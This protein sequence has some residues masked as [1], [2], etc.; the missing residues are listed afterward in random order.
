MDSYRPNGVTIEASHNNTRT[1][2]CT[3]PV[4]NTGLPTP[5]EAAVSVRRMLGQYE[6]WRSRPR[7]DLLKSANIFLRGTCLSS[8]RIYH[9]TMEFLFVMKAI[10]IAGRMMGGINCTNFELEEIELFECSQ[11]A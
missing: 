9:V 3:Y 2:F 6:E 7:T 5:E 4:T 8:V 10:K 11:V 1:A